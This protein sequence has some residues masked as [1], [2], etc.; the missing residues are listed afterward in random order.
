MPEQAYVAESV[1]RPG[2][3]CRI[4]A[5][6]TPDIRKAARFGMDEDRYLEN[7]ENSGFWKRRI[8]EKRQGRWELVE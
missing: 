8:I 2:M 5:N 7:M 6:A 4:G 3:F 1:R